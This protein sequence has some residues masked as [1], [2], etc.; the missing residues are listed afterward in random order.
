MSPREAAYLALLAALRQEGFISSFLER[1]QIKETPSP[2]DFALAQEISYGSARMALALDDIAVKLSKQGKLNLKIKEKALLRTA[3]YQ[4]AFLSKIPLYA[5][6]NETVQLAKKYCHRSFAN[7]LN[8]LLRKITP[9]VIALPGGDS[10]EEISIRH[11]FPLS[12]VNE[13]IDDYGKA[14]AEDILT[15]SNLPPKVMARLRPNFQLQKSNLPVFEIFL[16]TPEMVIIPASYLHAAA[17]SSSLYIQNVTPVVL[18]AELAQ[19]T[20]P[21]KN[22]LDLC[23]APGGKLLAAHDLFPEAILFGNDISQEKVLRLSQN[24]EKYGVHA[25]FSCSLGE[26][27]TSAEVFDLIILDVPCSNS[28]V[29]NKRPEARWRLNSVSLK[30]LE[31]KQYNLIQHALTLLAKGG[32]IWYL[33]C[34]ILKR[35]NENLISRVC[36]EFKLKCIYSKTILPDQNGWDGGFGCL[37][38]RKSTV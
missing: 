35:E 17:N 6:V 38:Q 26:A 19:R 23:A 25:S 32:S 21:P 18:I 8:A 12:F 16:N 11:S 7:Y 33:T 27:Y 28:G 3:I 36:Q 14:K 22:I 1:W 5:I 29:L 34:S 13:L 4:C 30:E 37:L 31:E 15:A 2:T 24:F 9:D 10:P 20:T